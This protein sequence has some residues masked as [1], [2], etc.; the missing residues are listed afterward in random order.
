MIEFN[1]INRNEKG[2]DVR[3]K[4]NTMLSELISGVEGIN[5]LWKDFLSLKTDTDSLN[6]KVEESQSMFKEQL[7]LCL[8]Q[9]DRSVEDLKSYINGMEG[10]VSAFA[11]DTNYT[12]NVPF[13]KSATILATEAGTYKNILDSNGSPITVTEENAL[14]IFYKSQNSNYWKYKAILDITVKESG[15]AFAGVATPTTNP[16]IPRGKVF[17]LATEEGRYTNFSNLVIDSGQI[18]VLTWDGKWSKQTMDIAIS[19][20]EGGG[21]ILKITTTQ[22]DNLFN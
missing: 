2:L 22:I 19:G 10:G 17:Y 5:A 15:Y 1:A 7:S 21:E 18:G 8:D 3:N 14:I 6:L 16:G 20:G 13:E 12:P 4:L 11:P 9:I